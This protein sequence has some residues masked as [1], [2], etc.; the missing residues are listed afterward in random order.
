MIIK[1]N[2]FVINDRESRFYLD[3]VKGFAIPEIRTS[4][5]VL[6]ER[7]GGYVASQFY[8]M[9]KVSIQGRIFGED[10]AELEEKRKEIMAAVR[11]RSIAIELITNAGNSYLVNGH[12]TDSEMDFDRL[13]NSSDFRFEFLCPDPVIY[14]NTDG[15]ALSI[16][17]GKQR[18]GGYIFPY[19]LPVEWQSGSGEVTARNNGN[20]PVKPVIKFKGSMTDPTLINVTTGKLVQLSGFSAPEGSEVVIDTRTRSVLLNGGNIFDKLSDQSTFFSLQ[21]GDN[22]FRLES[23]SGADTVVAIVEWRN[24]FMGV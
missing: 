12:L 2:N 24:G 10:E 17:V 6:T 18:G 21:P 13:I 19:V 3:T 7:D 22:V 20:T 9:R 11:Q 8:G 1:L 16:Q 15:T 5:A 4:S 14:D 23:A